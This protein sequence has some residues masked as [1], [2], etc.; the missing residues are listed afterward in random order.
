MSSKRNI[1]AVYD[2]PDESGELLYQAVRLKQIKP[3]DPKSNFR[4]PNPDNPP[5]PDPKNRPDPNDSE[6]RTHWIWNLDGVRRVLYRLPELLDPCV[7]RREWVFFCEGEKDTDNVRALGLV[8][9]TSGSSTSWKDDLAEFLNDRRVAIVQDNDAPGRKYAKKVAFSLLE[10]GAP[11]VRIIE[12]P[13]MSKGGDISDWLSNGG[14]KEGLLGLVENTKPFT[15]P[16]EKVSL[17]FHLTDAGNAERLAFYQGENLRFCWDWNKWIWWDGRRWD[18]AKGNEMAR[19]L[20]LDTARGILMNEAAKIQDDSEKRSLLVKW[21]LASETSS[22]LNAMIQVAQAIEPFPTYAKNFNANPWLA[23]CLNGTVDLRTGKLGPHN[24][25]DLITKICPVNYDP[26]ARLKLWESFLET[27]TNGDESLME[28]LQVAAGYS[29]CG[30]IGEE[31]LFFIHG[32]AATGKSTF[33]ET[34]KSALGEYAQTSDFETFLKRKDVGGTR[35]DIARL[36]GARLVASIEVDEGQR[37]AEGLIKMLTG[38]DTVSARFLYQ[39][40]FEFVPQFK[41]WLAANHA[42]RIKD[43]D[44]AIWRR[45]LRVPF[46]HAIPKENQDPK[47]K[48]TLRNPEIAGPAVLAWLVKG[49]LRWQK[50][51]LAVPEIVERATEDYRADQDPLK[52]FFEDCCEFDPTAFVPVSELRSAYDQLCKE[53]GTRYP[54]GPRQFNERLRAKGCEQGTK[55]YYNDFGTEATARCW[56]GV[57]LTAKSRYDHSTNNKAGIEERIPF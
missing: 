38:G 47:I 54:L 11:E 27:V 5:D 19:R 28:F 1:V 48:A 4:R 26:D 20:A 33:L 42:P 17:A 12:L 31:K 6:D 30:D 51:G 16:I 43:D 24:P 52:D 18:L 22:R 14:T 3:D 41:L 45:I 2:Y 21:S 32:D 49:C 36:N 35:N 25:Y 46:D 15:R 37:L 39:E 13:G 53:N 7:K 10:S 56:R 23:T 29:A 9:T 55:K 40:S 44:N 50:K 8:A 34:V 57:T